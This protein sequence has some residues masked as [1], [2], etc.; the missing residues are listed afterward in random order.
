MTLLRGTHDYRYFLGCVDRWLRCMGC[1][2][3]SYENDLKSLA[4]I[5]TLIIVVVVVAFVALV[6]W[7]VLR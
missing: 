1:A 2:V 6:A 3:M 7:L 5:V 4:N